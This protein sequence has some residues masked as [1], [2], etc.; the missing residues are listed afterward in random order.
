MPDDNP[1][2]STTV[3]ETVTVDTG[4]S[5]EDLSALKDH[6]KDFWAEQ[7]SEPKAPEAPGPAQETKPEKELAP[8]TEKVVARVEPVVPPPTVKAEESPRE[9]SD[10]EIDKLTL[11]TGQRPEVYEQFKVV[12]DKW[13]ADRALLRT[14][15]E[16]HKAIEAQL[17]EARAN[18]LT[19]ELRADYEQLNGMRRRFNIA[20]DPEFNRRY[21]VPIINQY[22]S[23]LDEAGTML[24][25]QQQGARWAADVKQGWDSPDKLGDT[26]AEQKAWWQ[27]AVIAKV[28][29]EMNRE[30]LR[31]QVNDLLKLQKDRNTELFKHGNDAASYDNWIKERNAAA[32]KWA[33]EEVLAETRIQEQRIKDFLP[34][35][36]SQAKTKEERAAIDAHNERFTR[37]NEFFNQTVQDL[38]RNG[39]RAWVRAAL[40]A[41]QTQIMDAQIVNLEKEL[42]ETKAE[43]DQLKSDLEKIN[44]ARR[45]ISQ[46]SGT[47]PSP[48]GAKPQQNGQ[49]LSIHDLDVRKSFRNFDWGDGSK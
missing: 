19:P 33:Q 34:V 28:S 42:K 7:D 17:N 10:D 29:D 6:F 32:N 25:D 5:P 37:L 27:Q 8:A 48:T 39:P 49:G 14:Q 2:I 3:P 18:Q 40:T 26:I 43:R 15:E 46:T 22:L 44:G 30:A 31:S 36:I 47:P 11:V 9:H 41:T 20:A 35:D 4:A 12:K 1:P 13:K 38:E 16:R 45:R 24:D 21:Q 23:I